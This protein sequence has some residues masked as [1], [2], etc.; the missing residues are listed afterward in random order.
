M[1]SQT[2]EAIKPNHIYSLFTPTPGNKFFP[3]GPFS[4]MVIQAFYFSKINE[5]IPLYPCGQ[6]SG[7]YFPWFRNERK[8]RRC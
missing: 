6:V 8:E 1:V 4:K 2:L 5:H 7:K 3:L